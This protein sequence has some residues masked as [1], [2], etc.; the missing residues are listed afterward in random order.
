PWRLVADNWKGGSF[1]IGLGQN[2]LIT[3]NPDSDA[4]LMFVGTEGSGKTHFGLRPL[5]AEALAD[6][7]Q[8]VVF[9]HSG[10]DFNL[11]RQH[12]NAHLALFG[13]NNAVELNQYLRNLMVE[14]QRRLVILR[15]SGETGWEY[16]QY[17]GN[18]RILAVID[19]VN[20]LQEGMPTLGDV[21]EL[22]RSLRYITAEG[23]A[24]GVNL[25]LAVRDPSY[26]N[27]DLRFRRMTS[28]VCFRVR[29]LDASKLILNRG[30]A[31]EL[32]PRQ[33]FAAFQSATTCGLAFAPQ[34][35]DLTA[36]LEGRQA[37]DWPAPDWMGSPGGGSSES[38]P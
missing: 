6:G 2:G 1:P 14:I 12:K 37:P 35:E 16:L 4:S 38:Q 10:T 31:Q 32:C 18:P 27:V 22:W 29:D 33:F 23:K 19:N 34:D 11:F 5:I 21:D 25:A 36:F 17:Q 13:Q 26:M 3:I 9:D 8:V 28:P 24:A 7:W 15:S 20:L 30:G